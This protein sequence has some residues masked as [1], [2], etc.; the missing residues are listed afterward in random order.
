MRMTLLTVLAGITLTATIASADTDHLRVCVQRDGD[1]RLLLPGKACRANEVLLVWN[2]RGP[3]G[4]KGD[5]GPQGPTGAQGAPGS[6]G[7]QG[8]A[9][10]QGLQGTQG[11]QGPQG[12]AGPAGPVD[13]S[14][15]Y[16]LPVVDALGTEIGVATDPFSGIV[17]RR[18]NLDTV[19]FFASPNGPY[20]GPIDFYHMAPD[21]SDSRYLPTSFAR[22]LAYYAQVHKGVMFYTKTLD[23]DGTVQVPIGAVEHVGENDDATQ[24]GVCTPS[25]G[26]ST[27]SL[28][29]AE[30]VADPVIAGLTPPLRVK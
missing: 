29:P 11:L 5:T 6:Q 8:P 27:A 20:G 30:A 4:P 12:V 7:P 14:S 26:S 22:G 1:V 21:C 9:G 15:L 28:G 25:V 3:Q 10:P 16:T 18:A 24:P 23:P 17:M 13:A 2:L 19:I